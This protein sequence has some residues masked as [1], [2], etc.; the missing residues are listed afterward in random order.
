RN[1]QLH[2]TKVTRSD[3]GNYTCIA[4]NSLQ[5]EIR[6]LVTLTVAGKLLSHHPGSRELLKTRSRSLISHQS[7]IESTCG[8][9]IDHFHQGAKTAAFIM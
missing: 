6:A 5:G 3:A 7:H 1:G 8:T 2:F 4:S 9:A